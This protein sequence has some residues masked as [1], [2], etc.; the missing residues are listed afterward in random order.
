MAKTKSSQIPKFTPLFWKSLGELISN[1]IRFRV[2]KQH[3][4]YKGETFH[5]YSRKFSGVGWRTLKIKGKN[6]PV[7]LDSYVNK[8]IKGKA[9]P[10][11]VPQIPFSGRTPDM[12]LTGK[13]MA[14]LKVRRYTK[15]WV[16]YGW[17]GLQGGIVEFLEDMKNYQIIGKGIQILSKKEEK[18]IA[19]AV[20]MSYQ[21]K[22]D[23]YHKE[24][25]TL[26]INIR[27]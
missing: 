24:D 11:G 10:K 21:K 3:K 18:I 12:T 8:K 15:D 16:I 25:I 20:G 27:F 9:A 19:E 17:M 7:F 13:T 2:K 1:K 22:I 14:D 4:N 23:K 6:Y 26:N 5:P